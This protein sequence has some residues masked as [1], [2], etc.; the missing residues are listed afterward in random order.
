MSVENIIKPKISLEQHNELS[1]LLYERE[2]LLMEVE[3]YMEW[4]GD[5]K[6]LD[7]SLKEDQARNK[8]LQRLEEANI[9]YEKYCTEI[10]KYI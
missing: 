4:S 1:K 3:L 7:G 9:L 2:C 8:A 10:R 6:H 5:L